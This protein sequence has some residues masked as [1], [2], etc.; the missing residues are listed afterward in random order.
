[1][2]SFP[3]FADPAY[4]V[5]VACAAGFTRHAMRRIASTRARNVIEGR[6]SGQPVTR[7][8]AGLVL[9]ACFLSRPSRNQTGV[10]SME[11]PEKQQ[12]GPPPPFLP[13]SGEATDWLASL[14]ILRQFCQDFIDKRLKL[15]LP[16]ADRGKHGFRLC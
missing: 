2:G 16:L 11:R 8:E 6:A 3:M 4:A 14:E 1:M 15:V 7:S 5:D 9:R 12:E 13:L 10:S